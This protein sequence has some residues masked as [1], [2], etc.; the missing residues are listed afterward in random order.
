MIQARQDEGSTAAILA[1]TQRGVIGTRLAR[2]SAG[3]FNRSAASYI[4]AAMI[5]GNIAI[6]DKDPET[7]RS[8]GRKRKPAL[9]VPTII[10]GVK[11]PAEIKRDKRI[12]RLREFDRSRV[13]QGVVWDRHGGRSSSGGAD[14]HR[15]CDHYGMM[16]V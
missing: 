1:A 11:S 5:R 7:W 15:R 14:P 9:A 16:G 2:I 13:G 12:R 3:L 4:P 6:P 10:E 8:R